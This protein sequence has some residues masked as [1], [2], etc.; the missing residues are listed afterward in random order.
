MALRDDESYLKCKKKY[1]LSILFKKIYKGKKSRLKRPRP[2]D[3]DFDVN[4]APDASFPLG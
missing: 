1:S 4:L 3:F 2:N